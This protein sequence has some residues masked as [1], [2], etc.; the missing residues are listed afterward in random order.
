MSKVSTEVAVGR[1]KPEKVVP[2]KALT[3]G[4]IFRFPGSS[5]ERCI[6]N[7]DGAVLFHVLAQTNGGLVEV[8][9]VDFKLRQKFPETLPVI[10]HDSELTIFPNK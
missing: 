7:D 5:F 1:K 3:P 10:P 9:S 4:D 6:V 8:V 2:L